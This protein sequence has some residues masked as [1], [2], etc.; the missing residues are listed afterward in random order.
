MR[1]SFSNVQSRES[2]N[3]NN[4]IDTIAEGEGKDRTLDKDDDDADLIKPP[5]VQRKSQSRAKASTSNKP[6]SATTN[7]EQS[8]G[9]SM[10]EQELSKL[11]IVATNDPQNLQPPNN[12]IVQLENRFEKR[13]A[14]LLKEIDSLR[15]MVLG[16]VDESKTGKE[17]SERSERA[18]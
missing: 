5:R 6:S 16:I 11:A 12:Q 17:V 18:L 4:S 7:L 15:S 1:E 8:F 10:T 14:D 3:N 2:N 9:E 13:E